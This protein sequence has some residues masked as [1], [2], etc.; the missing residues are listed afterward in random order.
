MNGVSNDATKLRLFPFS[1]KDK[2]KYGSLTLMSILSLLGRLYPRLCFANIFH[3]GRQP[4]FK[5]TSLFS[6]KQRESL[7]EASERFKELQRESPYHSIPDCLLIQNF[8][9]GLQQP[10]KT[11]I[12]IATGGAIMGKPINKVKQLFEDMT[13]SN[14]HWGSE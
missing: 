2:A 6:C 3:P 7:H 13:S 12:D 9:N 14:Y 11:S 1:L 10:M 8:Y 5:M 4:S